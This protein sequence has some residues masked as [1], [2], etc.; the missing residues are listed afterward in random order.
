[1]Q[2]VKQRRESESLGRIFLKLSHRDKD[3]PTRDG[4]ETCGVRWVK[5]SLSRS[6]RL[7]L[8]LMP[9]SLTL[10][11]FPINIGDRERPK[12]NQINSGH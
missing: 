9:G 6:E 10:L 11:P 2:R 5:R 7:Y 3:N 12:R 4:N 8:N 1:M